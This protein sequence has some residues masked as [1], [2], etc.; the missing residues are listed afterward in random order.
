MQRESLFVRQKFC[1]NIYNFFKDFD[2][3]DIENEISPNKGQGLIFILGMP[4]SGTS[5]TES[6]LSTSSKLITGGEKVFFT[7]QL[8]EVIKKLLVGD[9]N[10]DVIFY[11]LRR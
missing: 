3:T 6:V 2:T 1:F 4:R 8:S 11:W 5:L 10:L 9:Q 7:L